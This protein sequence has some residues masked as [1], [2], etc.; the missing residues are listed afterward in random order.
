MLKLVVAATALVLGSLSIVWSASA[1]EEKDPIDRSLSGCLNS[2]GGASTA[3]Q[4]DCATKAATAWDR[5]L[6]KIYQKLMKTLDPASRELLRSSQR[7]WLAFRDA[8]KRFQTGP[9]TRQQGSL[10]GV[11]LNLANVEILR[12]RVM[13]FRSYAGGN[14]M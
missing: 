6:N 4:I 12:S 9:W 8:E 1:Q 5:E 13:T 10:I 2:P 7:Q 3:G 11:S 14:P